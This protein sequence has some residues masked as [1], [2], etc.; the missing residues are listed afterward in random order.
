MVWPVGRQVSP[1]LKELI[2]RMLEKSPRNR[3]TL[4]EM[5]NFNWL[6]EGYTVSL[7]D[8]GADILANLSNQELNAQGV[9]RQEMEIAQTVMQNIYA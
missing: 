5:K 3:I 2:S 4:D 1:G 7:A 8:Q 9:S 6:N